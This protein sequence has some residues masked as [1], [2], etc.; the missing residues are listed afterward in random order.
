MAS[1]IN[2]QKKENGNILFLI[3]IAVVLFAA[4]SYAVSSSQSGGQNADR[5]RSTIAASTLIQ[6][7]TLIK[8]TIQRMKI[9]NNCSDEDITFVYDSDLDNDLDSDDDYWNLNLPSTKCYVFHP[10]GGGLR[11]P[12]P[13]KDIGA[14][15]EI[16]FTGFNWV[17]DV[18]T[19]AAD[20]IAITTNITRTACDQI[21]RELGAPTTNGEPVEEGSNV[22]SSTFLVLT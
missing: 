20:L 18:G 5:E 12:E 3:L 10:D 2:K 15:S 16:I 13:A 1:F 9:L 21:N 8:N 4:L 22:E 14:G 7:I 11:F 19:S 17:D 6:E